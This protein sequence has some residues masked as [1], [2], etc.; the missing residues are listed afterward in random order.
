MSAQ[1]PLFPLKQTFANAIGMSVKCHKQKSEAS[2]HRSS[3]IATP[4]RASCRLPLR[5][6]STT[7]R[8]ESITSFEARR[9]DVVAAL[10]VIDVLGIEG[11]CQQILSRQPI[12]ERQLRTICCFTLPSTAAACQ[13]LSALKTTVGSS[14]SGGAASIFSKAS[15]S[16]TASGARGKRHPVLVPSI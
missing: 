2:P 5:T 13:D 8:I 16:S 4:Q 1:C 15:A 6:A 14:G 12:R 3:S 11:R 9:I 10:R 7:S